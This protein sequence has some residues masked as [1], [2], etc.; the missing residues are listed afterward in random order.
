MCFDPASLALALGGAVLSGVGSSINSNENTTNATNVANARNKV[1]LDELNKNNVLA[2]DARGTFNTRLAAEQPAATTAQ[3]GAVTGER[4]AAGTT[5]L[6]T[7]NPTTMPGAADSS[8]LVKS[9]VANAVNDALAKSEANATARGKLGGYGDLFFRQGM[10]DA[11]AGRTIGTDVAGA[12]A[13]TAL[14]PSLQDLAGA[15]AYKPN[16]GLG[17][18]LQGLGS[19][20]GTYGGSQAH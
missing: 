12:N 17:G 19:A 1:L 15:D 5:N 9:S 6:P 8:A 11:D 20:F 7:I 2:N 18:I 4:T 16:S 13:N 10:Q 3:M 14:I